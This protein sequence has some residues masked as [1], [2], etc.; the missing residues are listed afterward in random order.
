MLFTSLIKANSPSITPERELARLTLIK[1]GDEEV[2]RR[3]ST[4]VGSRGRPTLGEINGVAIQGPALP[5]PPSGPVNEDSVQRPQQAENVSS[6]D[7]SD[8]TLVD[9]PTVTDGDDTEMGNAGTTGASHERANTGEYKAATNRNVPQENATGEDNKTKRS[10]LI[11][12]QSADSDTESIT[13]VA[14]S[15]VSQQEPDDNSKDAP[16]DDDTDAV[17]TE[18]PSTMKIE[19]GDPPERPPPVPPRPHAAESNQTP[20][21]ELELGAQQDVTEVIGNVSFQLECAMRPKGIDSNG[22]QLDEIKE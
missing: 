19:E 13:V 11:N 14:P 20:I 10:E 12:D 16:A 6:D 5:G 7:A 2:Y 21:D 8:V 3:R 15:A 17:M 18:G 22:E 1:S 9:T 4:T